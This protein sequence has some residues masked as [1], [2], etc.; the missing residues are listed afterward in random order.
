[1]IELTT[2]RGLPAKVPETLQEDPTPRFNPSDAKAMRDY[3]EAQGYV[4]VKSV[5][6]AQDCDRM[7]ALWDEEIKPSRAFIYR[8]ATAKA[9]RHVI[10][11]KG[12]IMNP[13]LNL[14]SVDPKRYP[15][16]R[17]FATNNIL[18]AKPLS[19]VFR[20]LFGGEV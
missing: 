8:Q 14:Q 9:E 18:T 17:R 2:Q 5:F 20:A 16:F 1:M 12:W 4:I 7:R 10:N 11:A 6:T 3:Y 15:N 13:I 19:D